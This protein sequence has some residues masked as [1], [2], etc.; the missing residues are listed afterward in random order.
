MPRR[1]ASLT[2]GLAALVIASVVTLVAARTQASQ[3]GVAASPPTLMP[4]PLLPAYVVGTWERRDAYLVVAPDGLAR[5][6]WQTSW[7]RDDGPEPCD[8]EVGTSLVFGAHAEIRLI[9]PDADQPSTTMVG[10]ILNVTPPGLF[11]TG[12]VSI[13]RLATDLIE[14]RQNTQTVELCRPPR[15]LNSCDMLG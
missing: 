12:P 1:S 3:P 7:C 4:A 6:R 14:L 13:V 5:F 10:R 11:A 8:R 9:G 2:F 15:E